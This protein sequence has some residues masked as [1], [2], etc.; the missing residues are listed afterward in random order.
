MQLPGLMGPDRAIIS[1]GLQPS[2]PL[3]K[4]WRCKLRCK[5]T[6]E[7]LLCW[8]GPPP[9]LPRLC[10]VLHPS[11]PSKSERR[12]SIQKPRGQK[13]DGSSS[14]PHI[15]RHSFLIYFRLCS[16]PFRCDTIFPWSLHSNTLSPLF[17]LLLL[18]FVPFLSPLISSLQSSFFPPEK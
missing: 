12:R 14:S 4:C 18:T 16:S 17:S 3:M 2:A 6:A 9:L 15:S 11:S 8:P 10:C 7:C 1:P 5:W 13:G